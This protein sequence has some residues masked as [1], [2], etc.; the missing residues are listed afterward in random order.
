VGYDRVIS[1]HSQIAV[2][3][4]YAGFDFSI[5][6]A[7]PFH[8][9]IVELEYGHRISGRMDFVIAAGP[10]ITILHFCEIFISGQCLAEVPDTRVGVAGRA[11]LRYRFPRT[12]LNALYTRVQ[13]SGSG[14]FAGALSDVVSVNASRPLSRVWY[15]SLDTGFS[16][17]SRIEPSSGGIN[18]NS[19]DYVFAGVAVH[20]S[21]GHSFHV[22]GS[23]Q[24][25]QLILDNSYCM[26][27]S[28][29]NRISSRNSI[30]VG[31]DWRPRPIRLD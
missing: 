22:F 2:A 15:G 5:P 14:L 18:A 27:T 3:Y 28:A 25:N 17:N 6:D 7:Y 23:Y 16:R 9:S 11:L 13:T 20:R 30:T 21:F 8:T 4:A 1:T 24:F 29:C 19:Y 26:G 31:L 12:S 10:Q